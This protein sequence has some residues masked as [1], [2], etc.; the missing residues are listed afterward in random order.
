YYFVRYLMWNFV[1][2]Q[3]DLEGNMENTRGNWVSGISFIDDAMWGSQDQMPSK[4]HN[5]SSV[6]FFFLPL[7]LGLLGAYFQL[8]KD[9]KRFYAIL[10]LFILTSVGIIF[11]TGV[12]PF[13]PRERDYAM[14]GSFYAFA[15]WVGLGAACILLFIQKKIKSQ[16][17]N[18][19][20]GVVLMGIPMMM[21]FQNYV[22][23]DRSGRETAYDYAYSVLKSLPK[24]SILF[25][26]GDND[27]YPTWTIQETERF[28][29]DVKVINFTLLGTPWNIDQVK[30]R[31][32]NAMPIPSELSHED[33]REGSNDQ[34]YL[35]R[36]EMWQ[37]IFAEAQQMGLSENALA[38][39]KKYQTQD[40][41]SVKEAMKFLKT[42]SES[43]DIILQMLFGETK[44]EKMNFLP[45]SKFIIPVNKA[46]AVKSGIIKAKDLA[47]A[48]NE[49]VV[50]YGARTMFKSN[51]I[52]LDILANFD[53]KR[54][55][56][57]SSGGLYDNDNL[58]YLAD[59]LQFDGFTYR[60]VP[61]KTP[62]N[63]QGDTG[64]VDADDLY[65]VVKN[66]KWGGFKN[67]NTHF[68]ETCTSNIISYRTATSRAAAALVEKGNKQKALE[69]LDLATAEIP[70][71]K[72]NDPR[73]LSAM[74]YG[75]ILAGQENKGI[76]LAEELKKGIFEEYDYYLTL[77]PSEQRFVNRQMRLKP[78]EYSLVVRAVSDAYIKLGKKDKGY[79]YLVKSLQ[80]LDKRYNAF[81]KQLQAMG[82]EKAY[83]EA[84]KIQDIVPFYHY[85]FDVMKPYDST[86][87]E[88]KLKQIEQQLM[89]LTQ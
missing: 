84:D 40:S 48:E 5:E 50:N 72:Y 35:M 6:A 36:P 28:R 58:F 37:Q 9:F 3:N 62:E 59:Y 27:T 25:V 63:E 7:L 17:T 82:K 29:D 21:G 74:V 22:P 70:V 65:N 51:L 73:S 2:R 18:I 54:P 15:V 38:E 79:D 19:I 61:I 83:N 16:S 44:Y 86:Y 66:F 30:R 13:E 53:W 34:I 57:F 55:I 32:Y 8:D 1:G 11:Y 49:I 87:G 10:S 46:N 20:A 69:L 12:K 24:E 26:Y 71:K 60:L 41:I 45:V 42:K 33:Y 43:K 4:F 75:Y 89:K 85:I 76:Q 47:I 52:L 68:D 77:S 14:V 88:E 31:T 39:F 23:H 67:L 81:I 80:P 78:A 56:S 64:R